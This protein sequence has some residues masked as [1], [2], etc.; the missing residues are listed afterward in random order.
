[1]P[2]EECKIKGTVVIVLKDKDGNIKIRETHNLVTNS[3]DEYYAEVGAQETPNFTIAGIRLGT[4]A[5]AATT[6]IK[7]D[8]DMTTTTGS[9]VLGGSGNQ[10]IDVGYPKSDD[11]DTDNTGALADA[12]TWRSSW[13]TGEGNSADLATVD[14]PDN[15]TT[16]TKSLAIANFASKFT[17]TSSDTLKVFVNH[18]MLGA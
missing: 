7:T 13:G 6:P 16:P 12:V 4:N 17:K 1:M 11:D 3:G 14:L 18:T 5:G 8:V 9:S 15:L 2:D 10:P